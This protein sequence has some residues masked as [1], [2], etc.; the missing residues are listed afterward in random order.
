MKKRFL[1]IVSIIYSLIILYV[2]LNGELNSFLAPS[3]QLYV[4]ISCIP[5]FIM[6]IIICIKS[7]NYEFKLSD[8]VLLI[9][10]VF[11]WIA[12][13]GRLT[14][15]LASNRMSNYNVEKPSVPKN[16]T[17]KEAIIENDD[18]DYDFTNIDFV[19]IDE[20][21][22]VLA[23]YITFVSKASDFKGKTIKLR[24]FTILEGDYIPMGYF[25]IGKYMISCCAADAE[26]TGFIGRTDIEIK[27]NTWYELSGVLTEY[28][29]NDESII[30]VVDVKNIIEIN[31]K[32][33]EPYVYP[34]FNYGDGKC[35]SVGKYNLEY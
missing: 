2:W 8:L 5:L 4:K 11:L 31:E 17:E 26:F 23:D 15:T 21:Y 24:G 22:S 35:N 16:V 29:G 1:G 32:E 12:G 33:E 6:G 27:N 30:M 25:A 19:V 10:I 3:L 13:D 34:C 20:N 7:C 14:A 18:V 28:Q 9:P